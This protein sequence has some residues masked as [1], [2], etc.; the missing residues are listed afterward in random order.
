[1]L[2]AS[3]TRCFSTAGSW[4]WLMMY[5]R[6][7]DTAIELCTRSAWAS[8]NIRFA[9]I[10]ERL[11]FTSSTVGTPSLRSEGSRVRTVLLAS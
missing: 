8:T 3:T 5:F 1:M 4:G 10:R 7:R 6:A 11:S 9:T 2:R